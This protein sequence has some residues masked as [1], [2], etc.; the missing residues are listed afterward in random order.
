MVWARSKNEGRQTPPK[1][2]GKLKQRGRDPKEDPDTLGRNGY[3]IFR[4]KR[5]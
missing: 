1:C 3:R 5:T 2:P 4:G